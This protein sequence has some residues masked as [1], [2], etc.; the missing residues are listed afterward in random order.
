M[1]TKNPYKWIVVLKQDCDTKVQ[2]NKL[3][4]TLNLPKAR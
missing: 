1:S 3:I 4:K 2:C